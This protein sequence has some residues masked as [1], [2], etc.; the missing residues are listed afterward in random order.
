MWHSELWVS[1]IFFGKKRVSGMA[2]FFYW[3]WFF[4]P[5]KEWAGF[6]WWSGF[7]WV[8]RI[9]WVSRILFGVSRIFLSEHVFWWSGLFSVNRIFLS[10][11]DCKFNQNQDDRTSKDCKK[12]DWGPFFK[13]TITKIEGIILT[14]GSLSTLKTKTYC[15]NW[16][17]PTLPE[18]PV[19][20]RKAV[21]ITILKN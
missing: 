17:P 4:W 8:C 1:S 3:A 11:Q 16:K 9:F 10:E 13:V 12:F 5:K 15:P 14:I 20:Q 19:N 7:F 21:N 2:S 18:M 6:F